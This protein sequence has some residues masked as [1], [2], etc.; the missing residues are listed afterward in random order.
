VD[1]RENQVSKHWQPVFNRGGTLSFKTA[2]LF[3]EYTSV[4]LTFQNLF[5]KCFCSRQRCVV[6]GYT[7]LFIL[8]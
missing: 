7:S 8:L 1:F 5:L 6:G 3:Q 4:E 2:G